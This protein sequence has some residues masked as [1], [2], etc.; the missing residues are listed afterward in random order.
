MKKRGIQAVDEAIKNGVD[1]DG[2]PMLLK[3]V[4]FIKGLWEKK[5]KEKEA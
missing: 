5:T 3:C 2:T 4:S 1:F